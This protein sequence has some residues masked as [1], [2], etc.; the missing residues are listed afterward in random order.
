M[1]AKWLLGSLRFAAFDSGQHCLIIHLRFKEFDFDDLP[2]LSRLGLLKFSFGLLSFRLGH[3]VGASQ[4][5][6]I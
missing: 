1:V 4:L 2:L 3:Q 6:N 5:L